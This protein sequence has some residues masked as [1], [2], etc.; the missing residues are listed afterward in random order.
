MAERDSNSKEASSNDESAEIFTLNNVQVVTPS[1]SSDLVQLEQWPLEPSLELT[2]P[3]PQI[4]AQKA[5]LH[6][7]VQKSLG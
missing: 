6:K 5:V 3:L 1:N 2:P 7:V 4:F